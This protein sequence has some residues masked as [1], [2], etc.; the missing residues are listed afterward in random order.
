MEVKEFGSQ[1]DAE[2]WLNDS[3]GASKFL[4]FKKSGGFVAVVFN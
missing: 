1:T 2:K 3:K 4:A